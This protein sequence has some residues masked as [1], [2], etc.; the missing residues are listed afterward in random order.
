MQVVVGGMRDEVEK[1]PLPILHHMVDL[2][3]C[4]AS[5]RKFLGFHVFWVTSDF[6]MKDALLSVSERMTSL[7]LMRCVAESFLLC[8][9]L[10]TFSKHTTLS[11]IHKH[12]L[13]IE[14]KSQVTS[15]FNIS[16]EQ[17]S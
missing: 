16:V 6:E 9:Y 3:T 4:K 10:R 12:L 14:M 2:W 8:W 15:G 7:E 13:Q 11:A 17:P 5:G 1:A